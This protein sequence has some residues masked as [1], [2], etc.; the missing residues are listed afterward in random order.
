MPCDSSYMN[1]TRQEL[2]M[3][4]VACL[5]DELNGKRFNGAHWDGYHPRVYCKKI[6]ADAMTVKL[7]SRLQKVDVS[8]YSLEM[9]MWWRDHKEADK[10]RAKAALAAAKTEKQR[11]AALVKLTKH[12]RKLLGLEGVE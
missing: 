8:K 9:Q 11:K 6:N 10:K 4:R 12:E 7:C 2:D 3:S 1:P 5:I